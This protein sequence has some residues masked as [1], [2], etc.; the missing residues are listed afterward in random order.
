VYGSVVTDC[1]KRNVHPVFVYMELVPEPGEPWRAAYR[2]Q[3]L[4]LATRTGF[5]VLDLTGAYGGRPPASLWIAENDSHPNAFGSRLIAD[6]LF[7]LLRGE[8]FKIGLRLE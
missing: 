2:A 7:T 6:R 5:T 1:R 3:V 8:S 4:D